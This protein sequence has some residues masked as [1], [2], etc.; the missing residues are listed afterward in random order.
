VRLSSQ[1]DRGHRYLL[2]AGSLV[3]SFAL[4]S[5]AFL[6]AGQPFI[7]YFENLKSEVYILLLYGTLLMG[8]AMVGTG[9]KRKRRRLLSFACMPLCLLGASPWW[10]A[11]AFPPHSHDIEPLGLTCVCSLVLLAPLLGILSIIT[12]VLSM[13][14]VLSHPVQVG[15]CAGCGYNLTGLVEP[16]CPECGTPFD[17]SLLS[18]LNTP[19]S[20]RGEQ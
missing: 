18:R 11:W 17:P 15:Y 20:K 19:L 8:H 16:R 14:E 10:L 12:V 13:R 5:L 1:Q 4:L 9:T 6:V 3:I 7:K 2:V